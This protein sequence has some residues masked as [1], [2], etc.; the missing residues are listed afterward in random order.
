MWRLLK[1]KVTYVSGSPNT[2]SGNVALGVDP[3]P[4]AGVP[5]SYQNCIRH[6][7]HLFTPVFQGGSLGWVPRSQRDKEDKFTS[8]LTHSEG[9]VS[10]GTLQLYSAN[11]AASGTALGAIII[12]LS[13]R[14][15]ES[16]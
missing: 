7:S 13:I 9:E 12:D 1:M 16:C 3:E 2:V 14:F 8:L 4:L 15:S 6:D 5:G 11:S 10:F